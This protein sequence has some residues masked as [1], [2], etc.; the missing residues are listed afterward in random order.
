MPN[1]IYTELLMQLVDNFFLND[2]EL[3]CLHIVKWFKI[4]LCSTNNLILHQSFYNTQL[5]R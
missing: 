4:L 3:I 2:P 5:N 1:S